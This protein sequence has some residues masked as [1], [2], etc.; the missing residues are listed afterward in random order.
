MTDSPKG[1]TRGWVKWLLVVSLALNL[2][3][4]ALVA[5]ALTRGAEIGER[6]ALGPGLGG[7]IEALPDDR[8][9]DLRAELRESG[10]FRGLAPRERL[11]EA[12]ILRD[13][14]LTEPMDRAALEAL[15]T[16]QRARLEGSV[17]AAQGALLDQLDGMT[18]AERRDFLASLRARAAER[19]G[20]R[21]PADGADD[22]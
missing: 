16:G 8:R 14:L 10:V 7:L 1:T 6:T 11:R 2:L 5:G 13:A 12:R 4:L 19:R 9:Q 20:L 21:P 3:V 18:V 15:F 17:R 22:R